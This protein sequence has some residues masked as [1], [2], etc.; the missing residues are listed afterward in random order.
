[1][2]A[3][4]LRAVGA[5]RSIVIDEDNAVLAGNGVLLGAA[6]AGLTKV[7]IVEA[8]GDTIIAVRRRDLSPDQKRDLA[9]FDNRTAELAEWNAEQLGA[10]LREGVDLGQFFTDEELLELFPQEAPA[11]ARATLSDRFGVP[12]FSV[13]DARQ[14][15]WQDRKRAWLALGIES[16][17]G[18][19]VGAT[20][21]VAPPPAAAANGRPKQEATSAT[22][23]AKGRKAQ[24]NACP[25]GAPLPGVRGPRK[26]YKPGDNKARL[27][28][29][30]GKA[31]PI[32]GGGGGAWGARGKRTKGYQPGNN[33]ARLRLLKGKA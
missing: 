5:A 9:I 22:K 18:R 27:E 1:M 28:S 7:Q 17:L 20:S 19:G 24:A 8:R 12:P 15:Y 33:A 14:G 4:A 21:G 26:A 29:L 32:P 11:E 31:H 6:G 23:G 2:I 10:D 3:T 25:G 13:L 16:E 30:K